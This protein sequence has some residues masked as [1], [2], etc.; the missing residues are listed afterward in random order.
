MKLQLQQ[1]YLEEHIVVI[2][3]LL[4]ALETHLTVLPL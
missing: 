1:P 3:T 2:G 4:A